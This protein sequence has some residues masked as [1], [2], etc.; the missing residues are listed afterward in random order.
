M[1]A[2]SAPS[3]QGVTVRDVTGP[4]VVAGAPA[5]P[6]TPPVRGPLGAVVAGTVVVLVTY[7]TPMATLPATQA[8]LATSTDAGAWILSGM[9]VGLAAALL[10]AGL[11]GDRYGR[12]RVYLAGMLAL[13]IGA[14]L[15]GVAGSGWLL[16]GARILQGVGG[17]AVL[18]CGLATLAHAYP[19][20][21]R[22]LRAMSA[23]GASVGAGIAG[24]SLL[25]IALDFG[26][27]WRESYLAAAIFGLL[28]LGY[29]A[30]TVGESRAADPR[31]LDWPGVVLFVV[32]IV[33][34]VTALTQARSGLGAGVVVLAGLGLAMLGALGVVQRRYARWPLIDPQLGRHPRF[35]VATIGALVTGFGIIGMASFLPTVAQGG[36]GVSLR[37]AS[38]PPLAWAVTSTVTSLSINR[39]PLRLE[40]PRAIALLLVL[41]CVGM[42]TAIGARSTTALLVPMVLTGVTTGLLNPLLGREAIASVPADHAAMGSGVNNTARYLG[43]SCGITLFVIVAS[44][45]NGGLVEGWD[46]AVVVAAALTAAGAVA[47]LLLLARF[48]AD[49][50]AAG[51]LGASGDGDGAPVRE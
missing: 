6:T 24:G 8:D 44:T 51:V 47:A 49:V 13:A 32:A 3:G 9:S 42:L 43:A 37:E 48:R 1:P 38:V 45:A 19:P 20:G 14:L 27:G 21:P 29:A 16:A 25:A 34:L 50:A 46:R 2:G 39:L 31:P 41:T 40:G 11:L 30:R 7:V 35:L 22:R 33:L 4:A 10:A 36:F 12:R 26:T 15:C 5:S 18:A 17:A 28:A 23:W